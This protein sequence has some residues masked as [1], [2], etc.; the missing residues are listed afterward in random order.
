MTAPR[1]D[2]PTYRRFPLR[3]ALLS[4]AVDKSSRHVGTPL[5]LGLGCGIV[6]LI[7]TRENAKERGSKPSVWIRRG[8]SAGGACSHAVAGNGA[9]AC[10]LPVYARGE[11]GHL[12]LPCSPCC[13]CL[14][15]RT[16]ATAVS[17]QS[18]ITP[19]LNSTRILSPLLRPLPMITRITLRISR[20]RKSHLNNGFYSEKRRA[21]QSFKSSSEVQ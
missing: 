14:W 12:T 21:R 2:I 8:V 6:Y 5:D 4:T 18:L 13:R 9:Q 3:T 7:A 20:L 11:R 1:K 16:A 10:S 17:G 19:A 15:A